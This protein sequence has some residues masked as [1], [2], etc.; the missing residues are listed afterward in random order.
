MELLFICTVPRVGTQ[1]AGTA[2]PCSAKPAPACVTS[3]LSQHSTLPTHPGNSCCPLTPHHPWQHHRGL[4]QPLA[5]IVGSLQP[6]FSGSDNSRAHT[7]TSDC[8]AQT[9]VALQGQVLQCGGRGA[10]AITVTPAGIAP[11]SQP[12]RTPSSAFPTEGGACQHHP[13]QTQPQDR[14][15]APWLPRWP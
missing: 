7:S 11:P 12:Q 3:L 1:S 4:A 13:L 9:R 5:E 14:V 15:W 8:P 2:L 6:V 10:P